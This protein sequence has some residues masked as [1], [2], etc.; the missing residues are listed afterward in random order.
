MNENI[1]ELEYRAIYW[2]VQRLAPKRGIALCDVRA[3]FPS[4]LHDAMFATLHAVGVPEF[5]CR[6]ID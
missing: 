5:F 6:A 1:L 3:V 2:H 4:L